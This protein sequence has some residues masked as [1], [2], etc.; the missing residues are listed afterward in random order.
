MAGGD[1][2]A[3]HSD[4]LDAVRKLA[5]EIAERADEIDEKRTIPADLIKRLTD[6][7]AFRIFTPRLYGGEELDPISAFRVIEEVA[8]ADGSTGWTVMIAADFGPVFT[9]FP[10]ETLDELY[11]DGPDV[12]ARGAL[13]PKG[14]AVAVDG[15]YIVQGRWPL[16]SG[17][18][19]HQWAVGNC[20]VLE[21]GKPRMRPNGVPE[22]RL[23]IVPADQAEIIN[24]W[25][26][27]GMR[28]TCSDDIIIGEQFVPE[29]RAIDL[30]AGQSALDSPLYRIPP[31]V[32]L[33][34]THIAVACGIAA[35]AL[36]DVATLAKTKRPAFNPMLRLAT[37]PVFQNKLGQLDTRLCALRGLILDRTQRA[38]HRVAEGQPLPPEEILRSKSA[39]TYCHAES[40]AIA[41]EAF[42]I[43]GS[44]AIYNSS[45]LQRR[46]RDARVAA[47]HVVASEENYRF[48]GGLLAGE[49]LPPNA[50]T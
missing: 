20:I 35:G 37:D 30:F 2:A 9:L 8:K 3:A 15:G 49:E 36:D 42:A 17:S 40:V 33:G 27:V 7:G 14:V 45:S 29:R 44:T 23:V 4:V 39:V 16:A 18:Y 32:L 41:N 38:W 47:Q 48:L 34:P 13:A 11:A 10:R 12:F 5:P 21:E 50:L 1:Q 31:R 6:A 43:A 24:T 22:M 46:W 25:D 28:A 26:A 19:D